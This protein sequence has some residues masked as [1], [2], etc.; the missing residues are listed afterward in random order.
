MTIGGIAGLI[1]A[2]AFV[3]LVGFIG[4]TLI[5]LTGVIK[6]AG[7]TLEKLNTTVEVVTRDVDNLSIEVE[8]L[9]NKANTLVDDVNGKLSKTDPLFVAIGDLG[10]SVSD[11]NDSTKQMTSNLVSGVGKKKRKSPFS[12]LS[13]FTSSKSSRVK[14]YPR[15]SSEAVQ[16]LHDMVEA[17]KDIPEPKTH[18]ESDLFTIDRKQ[19]STT[20]GE[21]SIK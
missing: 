19:P 15:E 13:K 3:A 1:A 14:D 16:P 21:I 18:P 10:Q 5:S 20:A 9:L 6:E 17:K 7:H 2:L 11:L 8:G 12:S 4:Y